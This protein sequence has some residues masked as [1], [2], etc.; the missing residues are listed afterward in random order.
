MHSLRVILHHKSRSKKIGFHSQSC[1]RAKSILVPSSTGR[2]HKHHHLNFPADSSATST[3]CSLCSLFPLPWWTIL[4][5][6]CFICSILP[7]NS[8]L[9]TLCL[10]FPHCA[11]ASFSVL[12][13][14]KNLFFLF[15]VLVL[16]LFFFSPLLLPFSMHLLLLSCCSSSIYCQSLFFFP[17]EHGKGGLSWWL[18]SLAQTPEGLV[19]TRIYGTALQ[20]QW[21]TVS[22]Q[23]ICIPFPWGRISK[24]RREFA[25]H[26]M[27]SWKSQAKHTKGWIGDMDW[28][29][30]TRDGNYLLICPSGTLMMK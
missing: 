24:T 21:P 11:V 4:Q 5:L 23:G 19:K 7:V 13:A 29:C 28:G 18:C 10:F 3:H 26:Q 20:T 1:S 27:V 25:S 14:C 9:S 16:D 30:G 2:F 17:T 6:F 8:R 22:A 15:A 12:P